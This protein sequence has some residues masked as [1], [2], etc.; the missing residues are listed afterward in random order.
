[1]AGR[2][3]NGDKLISRS[4]PRKSM[5]QSIKDGYNKMKSQKPFRL[6]AGHFERTVRAFTCVAAPSGKSTGLIAHIPCPYTTQFYHVIC[7]FSPVLNPY[8]LPVSRTNLHSAFRCAPPETLNS[9]G[10]RVYVSATSALPNELSKAPCKKR[11]MRCPC[12]AGSLKH[13]S[14]M[15]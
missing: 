1:M 7:F 2:V 10:T 6:S 13:C 8:L 5:A 4:S 12:R 11:R 14:G 15:P 9:R 3:A